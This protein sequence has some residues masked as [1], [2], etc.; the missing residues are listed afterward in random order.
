MPSF[1]MVMEAVVDAFESRREELRERAP[2]MRARLGAVGA[3]EP[4][5]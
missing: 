2:E 4:A 5:D 1:R 3:V